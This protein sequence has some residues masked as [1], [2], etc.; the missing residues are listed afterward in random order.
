MARLRHSPTTLYALPGVLPLLPGLSIYSGMLALSQ[1]R[2]SDGIL[3]L[4]TATF[5][6]GAIAVGVAL[7]N[8]LLAQ[9]WR[10]SSLKKPK[11]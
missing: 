3:Q 5:L 9:L 1:N 10:L 7:S 4:I 11:P 6:G 2:S 8:S